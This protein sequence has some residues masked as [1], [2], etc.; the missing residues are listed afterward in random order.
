MKRVILPLAGFVVVT[1]VTLA[2]VVVHA[3]QMV[4]SLGNAG[5]VAKWLA[6]ASALIMTVAAFAGTFAQGK[7]ASAALEGIARNPDAAGRIVTP[8]I[9]AM[10]LI[11]SIVIFALLLA[12]YLQAKI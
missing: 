11:E 9:I 8:M 12:F 1:L 6:L 4:S 10:T 2:A 3:Q 7:T 5:S